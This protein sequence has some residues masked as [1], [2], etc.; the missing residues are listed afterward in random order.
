MS[1]S[2]KFKSPPDDSIYVTT[3]GYASFAREKAPHDQ[4]AI[5]GILLKTPINGTQRYQLKLRDMGDVEE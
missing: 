2:L 1:A 3:S 4:V 5:T